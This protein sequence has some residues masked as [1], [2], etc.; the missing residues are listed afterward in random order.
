M[1]PNQP[2]A[3][4]PQPAPEPNVLPPQQPVNPVAEPTLPA[5]PAVPT[6]GVPPNTPQLQPPP[7][8]DVAPAPQ[9]PAVTPVA[10][11]AS[12]AVSAVQP[13]VTASAAPIVMQPTIGPP[14]AAMPGPVP[15]QMEPTLPPN[16]TG[17]A[18]QQ[19]HKLGR[20][21]TGI[22]VAFVLFFT[23]FNAGWSLH[24]LAVRRVNYNK[25]D[26]AKALNAQKD[27]GPEVVDRSD[28]KLDL[29]HTIDSKYSAKDQDI[30][31]G[32]N[33]QISLVDGLC[34]MVTG[35]EKDWKPHS[36]FSKPKSASNY[37]VKLHLVIGSRDKPDHDKAALYSSELQNITAD[38][39]KHKDIT[40]Y[41][42]GSDLPDGEND[43]TS[44]DGNKV[45]PG[46]Q[47][48]GVIVVE[49][50]KGTLP[51]LYMERTSFGYT[52]GDHDTTS[53]KEFTMKV[54]VDI[55]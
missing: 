3:P 17:A 25:Q 18:A 24:V 37:F 47:K 28:G 11:Q 46:E 54:E 23:V 15:Q 5:Q 39:K 21:G 16:P 52:R 20:I 26:W 9:Q 13:A 8:T 40:Y 41:T 29:S 55:K 4:N 22:V 19:F 2:A 10:V 32:L 6:V 38:G 44:L 30:K 27:F 42:Y 51:K 34:F 14:P 50:P 49:V 31:A 33:Q 43:I 36:S 35:Y 45:E 53:F 1:Q 7:V 12:Q 48:E